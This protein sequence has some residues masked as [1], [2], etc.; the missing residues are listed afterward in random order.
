MSPSLFEEDLFDI[1]D[2]GDPNPKPVVQHYHGFNVVR[3]DLLGGGSKVRFADFI[4]QSNPEVEEWV[5]GSSP[6]TGYAQISLTCL[7][8]NYGKKSVL[9]MAK[10][11][12]KNLHLH[13]Y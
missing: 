4:I 5:Y 2:W 7:C 3:D 1:G 6:A 13:H 11:D 12:R 9:F 8:N 10:R